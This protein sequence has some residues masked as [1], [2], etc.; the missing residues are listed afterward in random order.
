M[1]GVPAEISQCTSGQK[2]GVT[3]NSSVEGLTARSKKLLKL[4]KIL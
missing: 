4:I 3:Q 1:R 2:I